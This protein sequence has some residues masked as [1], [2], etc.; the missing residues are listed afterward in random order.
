VPLQ[1]FCA[2]VGYSV[3]SLVFVCAV[4]EAMLWALWSLWGLLHPSQVDKLLTN[5]PPYAGYPWAREFGKRS[6]R[7]GSRE[8][9]NM[10]RLESGVWG[11][12]TENT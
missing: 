1:N 10:F 4:L 12:E 11:A 5:S 3:V 9:K 2:V 6:R 8:R 7:H